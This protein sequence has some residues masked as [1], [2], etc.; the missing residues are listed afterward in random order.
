MLIINEIIEKLHDFGI[1]KLYLLNTPIAVKQILKD[2]SK[3]IERFLLENKN[4]SIRHIDKN[5]S[6][7]AI[8]VSINILKIFLINFSV[9]N[10]L[11]LIFAQDVIE[12]VYRKQDISH[13]KEA[14]ILIFALFDSVDENT[15]KALTS[16]LNYRKINELKSIF[17]S[18]QT[19]NKIAKSNI[20]LENIIGKDYLIIKF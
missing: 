8:F 2:N 7:L 10:K 1:P 12:S 11:K 17:T 4:L 18:N 20:V 15:A 5:G 13:F 9:K 16:L 6:D 19:L 14:D 3:I